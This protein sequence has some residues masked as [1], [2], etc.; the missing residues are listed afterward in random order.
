VALAVWRQGYS[1]EEAHGL[2]EKALAVHTWRTYAA[3]RAVQLQGAAAARWF[4]ATVGGS[5]G[6]PAP[7][8]AAQFVYEDHWR[9]DE[10]IHEWMSDQHTTIAFTV[11]P[12]SSAGGPRSPQSGDVVL[13][14]LYESLQ[15]EQTRGSQTR[16]SSRE[17]SLGPN[18][19]SLGP[20]VRAALMEE[21][22]A[23]FSP[24][25]QPTGLGPSCPV[26]PAAHERMPPP[27]SVPLRAPPLWS[28]STVLAPQTLPRQSAHSQ[29]LSLQEQEQEQSLR[30]SL[31][32]L[33]YAWRHLARECAICIHVCICA[34]TCVHADAAAISCVTTRRQYADS[35]PTPPRTLPSTLPST[36]R[37]TR[38]ATRRASVTCVGPSLCTA[39]RTPLADEP[40]RRATHSAHA[41]PTAPPPSHS[42]TRRAPALLRA[43]P[44]TP[45]RRHLPPSLAYPSTGARRRNPNPNPNPNPDPNPNPNPDQVR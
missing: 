37:S 30:E 39:R 19:R 16:G 23:R 10:A 11:P 34:C 17:P 3:E 26:T 44:P 9:L 27:P 28:G 18:P 31:R 45:C 33:L 20:A 24:L 41:P 35:R 12:I 15:R 43:P 32:L 8:P 22:A 14:E 42:A 13:H 36:L 5:G 6:G 21:G 1:M 4:E 40:T 7:L 25:P 38:R 29:Q 2:S